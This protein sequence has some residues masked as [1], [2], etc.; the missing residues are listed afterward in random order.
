MTFGG[1]AGHTVYERNLSFEGFFSTYCDVVSQKLA[2]GGPP[3][4]LLGSP[5]EC[6]TRAGGLKS[7]LVRMH[8]PT[9]NQQPGLLHTV[10]AVKITIII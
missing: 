5:A 3:G 10:A 8:T 2:S 4:V 6:A 1:G 7:A 9:Y